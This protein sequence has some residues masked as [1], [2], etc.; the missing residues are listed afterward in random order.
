M[1]A[2]PVIDLRVFQAMPGNSV[3][4]LA[5]APV[6]TILAATDDYFRTSGRTNEQ[7]INKGILE[8]FPTP[9]DDPNQ[10]GIKQLRKSLEKVIVHKHSDRMPLVRYDV[11]NADGVFEERYWSAVNTPVF[12]EGGEIRYIIHTAE[13]M[14]SQVKAERD[15]RKIRQLEKSYDL[16]MQAPVTIGV[17]KGD[18]FVIELANDTLL[19]IWARSAEVIGKPLFEAIPELKEQGFKELLDQV[20]QTGVPYSAYE[21]PIKLIRHGK[22]EVLYF[23][24]V[25]KP[26]YEDSH[27]HPVG[28]LAVGH[29]VT[30]Q[31][32][33]RQKFKNV[34]EQAKDPIMI[35]EGKNL[36]LDT[37]NQAVFKLFNVGPEVL[38]QPFFDFLPKRTNQGFDA[39][40]HNV[41]VNGT[42]FIDQEVPILINRKSGDEETVY[43]DFSYQ[44]YRNPEGNITG[45]LVMATDVTAT[46]FA[47]KRIEE[48]E[49]HFRRMADTVPVIIWITRTDGHCTYLNKRWYDTTGQTPA[50]AEGFGWLKAIHPDDA[51]NAGRIFLEANE[52]HIPFYI[53][54]RLRQKNGEYRWAVDSGQPKFTD[55]GTFEGMIGTVIDVHEQKL[56]ED[57]IR[58]SEARFRNILE[59]TPEPMLVLKGEELIVEVANEPLFRTWRMDASVLG[60][61]L[62]ECLPELKG[63][64]IIEMMLDVFYNK[65]VIKGYDRP[66]IYD[67]GNGVT[68]TMYYNFVYSPYVEATGEVTGILIIGTDVTGSV[69]ARQALEESENRFRTLAMTIPQI[70]WTTDETGR[71]DYLSNQWENYTGQPVAE[72]L[73]ENYR[74]IHPEDLE[75]VAT[76]WREAIETGRPWRADYRLKMKESG[77]YRWFTGVTSPLK[78][79]EGRIV[80]WIGTATD[81][82]EQKLF[83]RKL[84]ALV[85]ERTGALQRSNDDLQQFAHVASHDLKE[86]VR[87]VNTF[88]SRLEKHLDGRL[89]ATGE[90]FIQRIYSATNRMSTMIDGVLKYSTVNE[91]TEETEAVD[92]NEVLRNIETDLE[93]IIQN[94]CTEIRY[95]RLPTIEGAPILIYQLFNNLI[96]NSIKF[97]KADTPARIEI[98]SEVTIEKEQEFAR[99][100]LADN[101]IGFEQEQA[102]AIFDTF[103]RLNPKDRYEGTGLGLALCKK[104]AERHGGSISAQGS[105]GEGSTFIILLP[106]KQSKQSV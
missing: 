91:A 54:Y 4:L 66:V 8:A 90:K 22:E 41:L 106:L 48:S 67:R 81:I 26:F 83:T 53:L 97:A 98:S 11:Q 52:K 87:K 59:Q 15:A 62:L 70:V 33:S 78:D 19:D 89:D 14:T 1:S 24:F 20:Y 61:P 17:V 51:A 68:E 13:E 94:T 44:P 101:G 77:K 5:D 88:L 104:I 27:I 36:V 3:V 29:N 40:L 34:I 103:T 85:H 74:M 64:G 92:L 57:K 25:Y 42:P 55:E 71:L 45:V 10:A 38:G 30:R 76:C 79:A 12:D 32:Q 37:A 50:D 58:A 73:G 105:L 31:V 72:G 56:A 99:V 28:V 23:D 96:N 65:K 80:R 84:E 47:R 49:S 86:P 21:H 100:V 2:P 43:F 63:Q 35:L 95:D 9:P 46:V 69:R 7:L 60:K 75:K 102:S 6:F 93:V 18:S 16:F 82:H 39:L